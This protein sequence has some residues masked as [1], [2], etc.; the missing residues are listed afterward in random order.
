[1]E[2]RIE[3]TQVYGLDKAIKA[4][5]NPMRVEIDPSETTEK[6]IKRACMLGNTKAGEGH[7]QFLTGIVVQFDIYAPLYMWKQLQRYHFLDFISSQS[8]MHCLTKFKVKDCCVEDTDAV[9]LDR[10]QELLDEYKTIA[11]DN[12]GSWRALSKWRTLVASLP[13]GFCLG[14]SLTTNYR[15]LKNIFHQRKNHKLKEWRDFCAWCESL[16]LFKEL[17]LGKSEKD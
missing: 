14:A 7:D 15:Q 17:V 6:D 3:N 10:Y 11:A 5:G 1:M 8:T 9:V 12:A 13:C 2:F 16:P 4:S